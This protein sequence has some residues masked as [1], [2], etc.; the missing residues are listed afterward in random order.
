MHDTGVGGYEPVIEEGC[1]LSQARTGSHDNVGIAHG[2]NRFLGSQAPQM[3]QVVGVV[4]GHGIG[5]AIRRYDGRSGKFGEAT[6]GRVG[7]APFHAAA[8][9]NHRPLG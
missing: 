8:G 4:V 9:H 1:R 3:A 7:K 6:H 5:S 2:I